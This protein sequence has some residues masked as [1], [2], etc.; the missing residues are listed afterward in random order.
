MPALLQTVPC[1]KREFSLVP[2]AGFIQK[3]PALLQ[4]VPCKKESLVL[5]CLKQASGKICLLCFKHFPEKRERLV[6]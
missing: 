4:T 3:L 6:A 5:L 1:K 2:K